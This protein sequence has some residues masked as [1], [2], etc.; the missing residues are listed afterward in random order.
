MKGFGKSVL[1]ALQDPSQQGAQFM[2]ELSYPLTPG[3]AFKLYQTNDGTH[4]NDALDGTYS[5]ETSPSHEKSNEPSATA[6][7]SQ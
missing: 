7:L 2:L 4:L 1:L 3:G 5:V 6:L